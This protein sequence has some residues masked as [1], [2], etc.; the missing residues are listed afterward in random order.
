MWPELASNQAEVVKKKKEQADELAANLEQRRGGSTAARLQKSDDDYAETR[1]GLIAR[2]AGASDLAAADAS[3]DLDNGHIQA[4]GADQEFSAANAQLQARRKAVEGAEARGTLSSVDAQRAKIAL[5][6]A[7]AEAL[8]P[9]LAQYQAL[10]D[11]GD[12]GATEKVAE[13]KTQLEELKSPI[14]EVAAH[15]REQFDGAF[16]GLFEN[17]DQGKKA[18]ESFAKDVEK[19]LIQAAFKRLIEPGLQQGLGS[20]IPDRGAANGGTGVFGSAGAGALSLLK[21]LSSP[22]RAG[23][24]VDTVSSPDDTLLMGGGDGGA[25]GGGTGAAPSSLGMNGTGKG[26]SLGGIFKDDANLLLGGLFGG[27]KGG[28]SFL[29]GITPKIA[30]APGGA[31]GGVSGGDGGVVVNVINQGTPMQSAGAS[32][33]KGTGDGGQEQQIISIMLKDA[34]ENGPFVQAIT[35]LL[36][37]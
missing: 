34:N 22:N 8:E 1:K 17:L 13:L 6:K 27:S 37:L 32:S 23:N 7:E 3:H 30:G 5:D 21:A 31:G 25:V 24:A 29:S 12:L 20:V 35:G 2:G 15:M 9:V 4:E 16:E 10:A 11:K 28:G 19:I 36:G 26:Y 14:D 33:S 18:W